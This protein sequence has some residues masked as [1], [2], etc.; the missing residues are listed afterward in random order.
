V[1]DLQPQKG[2]PPEEGRYV[3]FVRC[4]S[5]QVKDWLEPEIATWHGGRW[6]NFRPVFA[7]IGPLPLC[8]FEDYKDGLTWDE[9]FSDLR[10][11]EHGSFV[12]D[13]PKIEYDL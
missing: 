13:L 8:K 6:H 10:K 2:R 9:V 3:A 1:N 7:W 11:S 12:A 4:A 5:Y